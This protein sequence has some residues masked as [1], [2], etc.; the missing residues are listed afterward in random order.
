[1]CI[2]RR[3][4]TATTEKKTPRTWLTRLLLQSHSL[5]Q[6]LFYC[7]CLLDVLAIRPYLSDT[8][9]PHTLLQNRAHALYF[10]PFGAACSASSSLARIDSLSR[11]MSAFVSATFSAWA[12]LSFS[13]ARISRQRCSASD[14]RVYPNA[15]NLPAP[16]LGSSGEQSGGLPLPLP[17]STQS[18]A[19]LLS[20][21]SSYLPR[22]KSKFYTYIFKEKKNLLFLPVEA[23]VAQAKQSNKK[24]ALT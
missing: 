15:L 4:T 12:A 20:A 6:C 11:A 7:C 3:R 9:R 16:S 13:R 18:R 23:M 5:S 22:A 17:Y 14:T 21:A 1:M 8:P 24:G 10:E 19:E 2:L